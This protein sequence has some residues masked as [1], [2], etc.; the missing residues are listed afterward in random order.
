MNTVFSGIFLLELILK[1]LAYGKSY[2]LVGWNIFDFTVVTASLAD[3]L[4]GQLGVG[5]GNSALS[6]LPQI[7]R[8]SRVLRV[9]RIL[10]MFKRFK[11][12]Q[13]LIETF[14]FMMPALGNGL[15]IISLFMFISSVVSSYLLQSISFDGSGYYT[16]SSN[17]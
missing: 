6:V 11:G 15:A 5:L 4:M 8:I 17:F 7:A 14:I 10:R 16:T 3:F 9:T 13:K 2:F 12:L 1:L